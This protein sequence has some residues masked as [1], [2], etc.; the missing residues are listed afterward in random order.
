MNILVIN[1]M[2]SSSSFKSKVCKQNLIQLLAHLF[3][4]SEA[5]KDD[6]A[7]E[8]FRTC[9]FSILEAISKNNKLLM[10]NSKDIMELILPSIVEK[11]GS[12]S[13]DVRCQSLKAFTDFITQYLCDDKIYNCEE[14]TE[15]TQTIN[16]LI[17]KKLF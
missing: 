1:E 13:A 4:K 17:L 7:L 15:S 12:T 14:N 16:E 10:A 9:L 5:L 6:K 11:I 2:V 8:Q 3:E